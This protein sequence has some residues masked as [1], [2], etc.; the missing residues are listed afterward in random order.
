M[1]DLRTRVV[2]ARR[3]PLAFAGG[4]TAELLPQQASPAGSYRVEASGRGHEGGFAAEALAG[5]EHR[6]R[7]VF[8][9]AVPQLPALPPAHARARVRSAFV[10][11]QRDRP[12]VLKAA[13]SASR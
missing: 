9:V 2:H 11:H 1:E 10:N 7:P 4:G 13:L 12:G 8:A 5:N 3:A 6:H